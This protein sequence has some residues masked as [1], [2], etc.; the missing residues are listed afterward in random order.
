MLVKSRRE[1]DHF[2]DLKKTFDTLHSYNMKLNPAK[3]AFGVMGRKFLGFMVSHK[4]IEANLD[5]IRA[6]MEMAPPKNVKEVQSLNGKI[7]A[8]NRFVSRATNKC[9]PFFRT[10]KKSFEWTVE[11]QQA[12]EEL[13]AYLSSLPLLS[14]SQLGEELFLYLAISLAAVSAALVR[15]EERVQKPVYYT[16]WVLRDAKE[17][18]PPMEKLAFALVTAARKLKPYFQAHTVVVLTD[19]PLRQAISN[20]KAADKLALWAIELSEFDIQYRPQT[21]I[22]GQIVIDFIAEFT[23]NEDK[24]AEESSQWSIHV[25]GSSNRQV[26]EVDIVLLSPEGDTVECMVRFDFPTTNNE[27]KH[28]ALIAG[29]DLA[30]VAGALNMV[31]YYDSQIVAN[32]MN[33]DYECKGE[34]MKKYL[35]QVKKMVNE[36]KAKIIQIPQGENEQADRLA[37][38]PSA[39][40][41]TTMYNTLSF[42]QL[43]PLINSTNVQ[44]IGSKSNWTTP[45]VT[46][47]K[48]GVLPHKK[49][50]ARKLKVQAT[51]F[52]LIR[53]ILCKRGFSHSYLRC[54]G[55][56]EVDY[57]MRE[58]HEGICGN[59]S[60][61]RLLVHKLVRAGYFWPT[62]KKDAEAYVKTCDKCQRFSNI[63]RQPTEELTLITAPWLFAQWGLD[64]MGPLPTAVR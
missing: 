7:A 60:G 5:K 50:A 59:H 45:I 57:V 28:K 9:L 38:A 33:G 44:E 17:R 30:K 6:I 24:G 48:N 37:K 53:D 49:E 40:H 47:L 27:A 8:L 58:V 14:P 34:R 32:Q 54:L 52:V 43:S 63:I 13:K 61:S 15:G 62:M 3:C 20:P 39:E 26:G 18:Y 16:R 2:E 41:M 25:D 11:C 36:L 55:P 51:R 12:F 23:D 19:K 10:L 42:V 1:E 31:I 4:G 64:I 21:A 22:K 29:L 56:E 46:C 35:D